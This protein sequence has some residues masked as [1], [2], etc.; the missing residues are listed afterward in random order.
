MLIAI[1][2][3]ERDGCY[4]CGQRPNGAPLA[5]LWE[6][7]GGKVE[8]GETPQA[9]A[10]RECREETGL[11][12]EVGTAYPTVDHQYGHGRV[13][14]RFF[15]CRPR[16]PDAAPKPPFA[17]IPA[18][19]LAELPFPEANAALVEELVAKTMGRRGA[20]T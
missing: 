19:R 11:D 8:P 6:F 9:A 15:A 4:L 16:E 18:A 12:V 1:A 10:A 14:L 7:P 3:V 20:E 2:V 17:W 13:D 5:G